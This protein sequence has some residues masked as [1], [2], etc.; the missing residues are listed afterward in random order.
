MPRKKG[1]RRK[2][3]SSSRRSQSIVSQAGNSSR[4]IKLEDEQT[5]LRV[6]EDSDDL[7]ELSDSPHEDF[8]DDGG[9]WPVDRVVRFEIDY[10]GRIR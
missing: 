6:E 1:T 5:S 4:G 8:G 7:F 3:Q 10:K 2:S 9:E